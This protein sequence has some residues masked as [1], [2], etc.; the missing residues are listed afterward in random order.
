MVDIMNR[1]VTR[2]LSN[3]LAA[4][5]ASAAQQAASQSYVT[6]NVSYHAHNYQ[7]QQ[8]HQHSVGQHGYL[9]PPHPPPQHQQHQEG[10]NHHQ[11][12][13]HQQQ[14]QQNQHQG[15][16]VGMGT[17]TMGGSN[18]PYPRTTSEEMFLN[19]LMSTPISPGTPTMEA[20]SLGFLDSLQPQ[21]AV[22]AHTTRGDSEELF[23]SWLTTTA[24]NSN[25]YQN[26]VY[27]GPSSNGN[28]P[29][30]NSRKM[31]SELQ[32]ILAQQNGAPWAARPDNGEQAYMQT[33]S[34]LS[35]EG[36]QTPYRPNPPE[37]KSA[38]A[39]NSNA[40]SWKNMWINSPSPMT[41][42]RSSEMRRRYAQMEGL[43][44]LPPVEVFQ[45]MATQGTLEGLVNPAMTSMGTFTRGVG[46]SG[47]NGRH[48]SNNPDSK[49]MG[50]QPPLVHTQSSPA[51]VNHN[52]QQQQQQN[53]QQQA[54]QQ[55][56]VATSALTDV[57]GLLKGSLERKKLQTKQQQ[58]QHV[59]S[60]HQ[61]IVQQRQMPPNQQK[62]PQP[63]VRSRPPTHEPQQSVRGRLTP[64]SSPQVSA[65]VVRA[66]QDESLDK[67]QDHKQHLHDDNTMA[68]SGPGQQN[69]GMVRV[70]SPGESS[71][72]APAP[73]HS[74]GIATSDGPSNSAMS[75]HRH[76]LKR[77]S[78]SGAVDQPSPKRQQ[79]FSGIESGPC[80]G[81]NLENGPTKSDLLKKPEQLARAGSITSSL[82]SG[83]QVNEL[84]GD[85][86]KRRV[87]RQRKMAEAKGRGNAPPLPADMQAAVK[88]CDTLEK[89]VR[90]LKLNLAFMNRKDSEQTKKI[91]ELEQQND[92]LKDERDRLLDELDRVSTI[93]DT[94]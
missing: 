82:R 3:E 37:D 14:N 64:M 57:V 76:A 39:E 16:N 7:L 84:D 72:G 23:N 2:S 12:H 94:Q 51:P 91:E 8:Q 41:R 78:C 80:N 46:P 45:K 93:H 77:G 13:Q 50:S 68:H 79:T 28:R 1:R 4:R 18:Q 89:E 24:E 85:T 11:H 21:P 70:H 42:S 30:Q 60:L 59:P 10:I 86:R 90:S 20:A 65:V 87:E 19:T 56:P 49:L 92:E 35:D 40:G 44:A 27:S 48:Q 66:H 75:V 34:Y 62:E 26:G 6:Q 63:G 53:Q 5:Q 71:C 22:G 55:L 47:N 83:F 54:Q 69:S 32:A 88:R 15:M 81:E 67:S 17:A 29:R 58:Q 74:A 25:Q 36:D 61:Q 9:P 38:P 31:S 73:S 52:Q 43:P 33:N